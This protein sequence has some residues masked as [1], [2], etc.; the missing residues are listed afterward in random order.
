[1]VGALGRNVTVVAECKWTSRQMPLKVLN[2]LE[3]YKLPALGQLGV[4]VTALLVVLFSRSGFSPDLQE[5]ARFVVLLQRVVEIVAPGI[6]ADIDP[7]LGKAQRQHRGEQAARDPAVV[8]EPIGAGDPPCVAQYVAFAVGH[9][10]LRNPASPYPP[11]LKAP[12][13]RG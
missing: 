11:R 3:T 5:E 2:D 8:G 6:E 9:H 4:D 13:G 7:H 10:V 12:A 1:M